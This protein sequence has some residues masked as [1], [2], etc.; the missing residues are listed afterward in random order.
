MK[1]RNAAVPVAYILIEKDGKFL[2]G[3]RCNTGYADGLYQIPAGHIEEGELPTQAIIREAKEEV[4]V[5]LTVDDIELVH[6]MY[7]PKHDDTG[8][9]VGFFF[10]AKTWSGEIKNMEPDKC[11]DIKWLSMDSDE[12][13]TPHPKRAM[14]HIKKGI[15]YSEYQET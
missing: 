14:E 3:R 13:M 8:D 6:V 5:D 9:R 7:R 12:K 2:M 1:T 11:D 4:N 15:F 10:K